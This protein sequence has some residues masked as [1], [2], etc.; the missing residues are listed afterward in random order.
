MLLQMAEL[1][2]TDLRPERVVQRLM[3]AAGHLIQA[4]R[5]AL[6]LLNETREE[7]CCG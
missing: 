3:E 4:E 7:V 1:L 6:L 2:N 5:I